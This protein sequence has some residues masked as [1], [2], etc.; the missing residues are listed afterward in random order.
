M[1]AHVIIELPY[2][3][4]VHSREK[5]AELY[6]EGNSLREI[7]RQLHI[8]KTSLRKVLLNSGFEMRSKL[9]HQSISKPSPT[10]MKSGALPYGY[11][12]LA[13]K[14]V[15]EPSEYRNILEI[16]KSHKKGLSFR[17]IASSLNAKK[18]KTRL[19]KNWTHEIIKRIC[20]RE[21]KKQTPKRRTKK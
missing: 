15:I 10:G 2:L 7:E 20:E 19:G 18:I 5:I 17:S 9:N 1:Q 14:L 11:T 6:V 21:L 4:K 8:P 3:V 12:Q 13:G 16:I